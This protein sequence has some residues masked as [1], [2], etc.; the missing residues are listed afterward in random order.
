MLKKFTIGLGILL[1]SVTSH[2]FTL[3]LSDDASVNLDTNKGNDKRLLLSND[4]QG[5]PNN[6]VILNFALGSLPG[7]YFNTL[8]LSSDDILHANLVVYRK[9]GTCSINVN[10]ILD[11]VQGWDERNLTFGSANAGFELGEIIASQSSGT[12]NVREKSFTYINVTDIVKGWIDE[13]P[14]QQNG[15]ALT[16]ANCGGSPKVILSSKE[17]KSYNNPA[18]IEIVFRGNL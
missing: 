11:P 16:L 13:L 7:G 17:N 10:E 12:P 1:I 4:S 5:K 6:A 9:K 18:R 2:A 15:L 14:V 8:S 3:H